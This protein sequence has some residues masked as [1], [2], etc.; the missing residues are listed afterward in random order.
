MNDT[1]VITGGT[2]FIGHHFVEHFL[3][4]T[5]HK[6]AII[7][8]AT[9][10]APDFRRL[11]DMEIWPTEG[12]RVRFVRNDIRRSFFTK[13]IRQIGPAKAIIHLAAETHVDTSLVD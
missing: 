2:G 7:Y 8:S 4:N 6:L 12:R 3:K 1:V 11:T 5:Q 13:A 9:Y 10:S